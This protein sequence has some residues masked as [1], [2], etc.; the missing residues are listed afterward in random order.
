MNLSLHIRNENRLPLDIDCRHPAG[1]DLPLPT[2]PQIHWSRGPSQPHL[3]QHRS[4]RGAVPEHELLEAKQARPER[5]FH[6]VSHGLE[7]RP[8][9]AE[10][11]EPDIDGSANHVDELDIDPVIVQMAPHRIERLFREH[12]PV[13]GQELVGHQKQANGRIAGEPIDEGVPGHASNSVHQVRHGGAVNGVDALKEGGNRV[14]HCGIGMRLERINEPLDLLEK[15]WLHPS[16]FP[17]TV[18]SAPPSPVLG[19]RAAAAASVAMATARSHTPSITLA[20]RSLTSSPNSCTPASTSMTTTSSGRPPKWR[21]TTSVLSSAMTP[22]TASA[23][24]R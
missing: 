13:D 6:V 21:V 24:A 16:W 23:T 10:P 12:S 1:R 17:T 22:V 11:V 5:L 15:I 9:V 18:G 7:T 19:S 14:A 8:A 3:Q 2:G 4:G 20:T